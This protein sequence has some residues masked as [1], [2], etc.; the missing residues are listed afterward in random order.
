[1]EMNYTMSLF[2]AFISSSSAAHSAEDYDHHQLALTADG[3]GGGGGL[4][5]VQSDRTT[6]EEDQAPRGCSNLDDHQVGA[7]GAERKEMAGVVKKKKKGVLVNK[8]KTKKS[9]Y[10]FQTRSH[11][12]ILDDGYR[13]RK[14]GQKAVKNNKFPR[15]YYKCTYGECNVKKQVQRLTNDEGVVV[16]TYEGMHSHPISKHMD[17]FEHI[18]NQMHL[19]TAS[20]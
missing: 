8:K 15:S 1:M 6:A 19:F 12:D 18:L 3:G 5:M 16:T 14:Y 11:V 20:V 4:M 9:K 17:N 10:A 13:W 7:S 2:P